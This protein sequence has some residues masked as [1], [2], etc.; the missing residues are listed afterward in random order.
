MDAPCFVADCRQKSGRD[1]AI[2][3]QTDI[4]YLRQFKWE[5]LGWIE[6]TD[7]T[8]GIIAKHDLGRRFEGVTVQNR[9]RFSGF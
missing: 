8:G 9:V 4:E 6:V 7:R 3:I 2:E 5:G 1:A